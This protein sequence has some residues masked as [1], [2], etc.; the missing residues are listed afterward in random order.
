M[1]ISLLLPAAIEFEKELRSV[2]RELAP[3]AEWYPHSSLGNLWHL[4]KLLSTEHRDLANL[5]GGRAVADVGAADGDLAFFLARQGVTVDVVDN[6]ATNWNNLR[7][8]RLL[9]DH[10]DTSVTIHEV[11]LDTQFR[12][13]RDRYGLVLLLG[14]LYHLQ[15]PFYVLRQLAERTEHLMLSTRV[16]RVTADGAVRLDDAPVA[17]LVDPLETNNDATNYWIFSLSGLRRLIKR[18]GWTVLDEITVGRT[19]GDSDPS[20]HDRD[21][22][23][24]FLL[25]TCG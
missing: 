18:S 25:R 5:I 1:E 3:A 2:K 12:L 16:A 9:A 13:P 11:D 7:G 6:G 21:E 22:R 15:N 17:Y 19:D 20:G 14:L 24:F 23:A 8:A 4:D 10:F